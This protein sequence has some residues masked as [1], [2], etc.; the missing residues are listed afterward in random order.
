MIEWIVMSSATFRP[1]ERI[2][3]PAVFRNAFE[4]KKSASDP[5]LIIYGLEN[6]LGHPR[7]GISASKRKIRKAVDRN[8]AKRI[9]RE[10]FRL[11]KA[12]LPPGV[13]LIVVPKGAFLT[14]DQASRSLPTLA[15]AVA[16]RLGVA[17]AKA[18][19]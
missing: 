15:R 1:H 5:F 2:A 9:L 10:A 3:D 17:V 18:S 7:L 13:D 19:S 14:F 16:R 11:N 12:E 8:H 6:S 4:R